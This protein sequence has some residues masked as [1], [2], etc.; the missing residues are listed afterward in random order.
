MNE[1]KHKKEL[2]KLKINIK[3]DKYKELTIY[4][5][6]DINQIVQQFCNENLLNENLIE[7]LC[8]KIKQSLSKIEQVTNGAKLSRDSVLMLEKAKKYIQNK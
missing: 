2:L 8:N 5:E 4:K 1:V 7:P 6:D 3:E